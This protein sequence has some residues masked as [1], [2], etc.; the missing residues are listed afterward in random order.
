MTPPLE[1][2]GARRAA[3]GRRSAA[4]GSLPF[5]EPTAP[6]GDRRNSQAVA[7]PQ[8]P[9]YPSVSCGRAAS[10]HESVSRARGARPCNP[11][12]PRC[13]PREPL[14]RKAPA[15]TAETQAV[16]AASGGARSG[17]RPDPAR[18]VLR[19]RLTNL[20][21]SIAGHRAIVTGAASGM[22]RAT[23]HLFADEGARSPSS[24]SA[25]TP[26]MPSSRRSPT[27][28]APTPRSASSPTSLTSAQLRG[29]VTPSSRRLG[30]IDLL[31][32]NAGVA[33]ATFS[34]QADDDFLANWDRTLA[35]NLTAHAH[36]VRLAVPH[37]VAEQQGGSSTSP[38]P[39]PSSRPPAWSATPPP[40]PASSA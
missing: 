3:D 9:C 26:S 17:A 25:R 29:L 11:F 7:P 28:T 2:R 36:L 12:P 1:H 20:S 37:L 38:R 6:A 31:V 10:L 34:Q 4:V 27:P 30:G 32:N 14:G 24:T 23:A 33:L 15:M 16:S 5:H 40:R 39:R 8:P 18:M 22:G 35:V 13:G 21:R 19:M